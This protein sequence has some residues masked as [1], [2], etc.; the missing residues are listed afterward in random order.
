LGPEAVKGIEA[1]CDQGGKQSDEPVRLP[2]GRGN[3][4]AD[5]GSFFVPEPVVIGGFDPESV[6]AGAEVR[7][8]GTVF[9]ANII[10]ILIQ[11][12]ELIGILIILRRG[13]IEG[14]EIEGKVDC[15]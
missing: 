3:N 4:D 6:I 1:G 9:L 7:V 8:Y 11:T 15:L 10:P 5:S 2:E 14:G 13:I 12:F